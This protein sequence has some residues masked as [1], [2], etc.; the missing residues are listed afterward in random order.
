[1]ALMLWQW[2]QLIQAIWRLSGNPLPVGP[3]RNLG[4][5]L[6]RLPALQWAEAEQSSGTPPTVE[7][8]QPG[9]HGE[10]TDLDQQIS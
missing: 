2:Q 8:E 4:L 5:P 10:G 3:T 9:E 1:M 6:L 7:P